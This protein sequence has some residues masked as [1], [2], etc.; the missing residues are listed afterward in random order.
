VHRSNILLLLARAVATVVSKAAMAATRVDTKGH[1]S[2]DG[3]ILRR[4]PRRWR[5]WRLR[6]RRL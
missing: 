5:R 3:R 6:C 1:S 4:P 2:P